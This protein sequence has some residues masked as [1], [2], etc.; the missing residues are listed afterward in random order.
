MKIQLNSDASIHG[1]EALSAHLSTSLEGALERFKEEITRVDV[2][3]SDRRGGKDGPHYQR[4][5]LEASLEGRQPVAVMDHAPTMEQAIQGAAQ[6]LARMLGSRIGR[7]RER[8]KASD[9]PSFGV[10]P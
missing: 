8:D 1:N 5:M 9:L 10:E 7:K 6:K 4:C 3:L 2:H